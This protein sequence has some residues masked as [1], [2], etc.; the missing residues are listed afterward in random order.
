VWSGFNWLRIG[1]SGFVFK[2][3]FK[4]SGNFCTSGVNYRLLMIRTV[5]VY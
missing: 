3:S 5:A 4:L 2:H 1:V